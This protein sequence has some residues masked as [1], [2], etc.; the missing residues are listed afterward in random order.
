VAAQERDPASM[1]H[2]YRSLLALRRAHPELAMAP[3]E[4]LAAD[5]G[6]LSY[7][8]DQFAIVANLT[9]APVTAPFAGGT[10]VLRTAAGQV[11]GAPGPVVVGPLETVV[12][13]LW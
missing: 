12:A 13:E 10:P 2:L 7:R 11:G 5:S 6:V 9:Q 4:R 1:L 3:M 8:R